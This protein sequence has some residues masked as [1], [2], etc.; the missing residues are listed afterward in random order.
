MEEPQ[1]GREDNETSCQALASGTGQNSQGTAW[2]SRCCYCLRAWGCLLG[3]PACRQGT[4]QHAQKSLELGLPFSKKTALVPSA[5]L[6]PTSPVP[7]PRQCHSEKQGIL[8]ASLMGS[9]LQT[10]EPDLSWSGE[11]WFWGGQTWSGVDMNRV[12]V[13]LL[14]ESQLRG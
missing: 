5:L 7:G 11:T 10:A 3:G 14:Q 4:G 1:R 12:Q 8:S 9:L 2:P 13:E 6:V